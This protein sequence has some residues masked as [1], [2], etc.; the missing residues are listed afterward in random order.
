MEEDTWNKIID[1][2]V[3]G[4][5]SHF[6]SYFSVMEPSSPFLYYVIAIIN[7]GGT[8]GRSL[9]YADFLLSHCSVGMRNGMRGSVLGDENVHAKCDE[10]ADG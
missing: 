5:L 4:S 7:Q 6:L 9:V 3:N 2:R 1:I 10:S 8:D